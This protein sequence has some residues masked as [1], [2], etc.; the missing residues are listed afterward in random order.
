MDGTLLSSATSSRPTCGCG[1][2]SSTAA[3]RLARSAGCCAGCRRYVQAERRDR[4]G[5]LR[6]VYREYAGAELAE[7]DAARRRGPHRAR[8][9]AARAAAVRRVREHRA[10]GHRTVLITG[11]I[12]P[13][14]RPLAPLFDHIEAADLAVDERGAGTGFLASPPL[15]GESR[16]AWLR[17]Y[18]AARRLS[19]CRA[20]YALRRQLLR[21]ADAARRSG[22]P[23]AI[24][25]DV[26]LWREARQVRWPVELGGRRVGS[27]GDSDRARPARRST[28]Q[29]V[30]PMMLALEMYRSVSPLHARPRRSAAGCPGCWS[31]RWRRCG[32]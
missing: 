13:L 1:C 12:R 24:S 20:S 16:A 8:A 22:Y 15:V 29:V 25:P 14:T 3:E 19:T 27:R 30:A 17:R 31:A 11:A 21:P 5:F 10:A 4:G 2:P 28:R 32:W 6:A 26:P 18:A 7:L 9:G 23:A